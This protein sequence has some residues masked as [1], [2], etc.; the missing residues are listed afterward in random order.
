MSIKQQQ[1]R[2]RVPLNSIIKFN[3]IVNLSKCF[4]ATVPMARR[5]IDLFTVNGKYVCNFYYNLA[6]FIDFCLFFDLLLNFICFFCFLPRSFF[7]IC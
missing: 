2:D 7:G 4:V 1:Q 3:Q 6:I 5:V